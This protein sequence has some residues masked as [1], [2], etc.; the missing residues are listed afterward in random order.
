MDAMEH[1]LILDYRNGTFRARCAC[2]GW[3][4]APVTIRV[5]KLREVYDRIE[6]EHYRHVEAVE[7]PQPSLA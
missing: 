2:G 6:D 7:T 3:E 1:Q 4:K 5:Q